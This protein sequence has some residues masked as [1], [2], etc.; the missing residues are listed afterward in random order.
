M[1]DR[2]G[3]TVDAEHRHRPRPAGDQPDRPPGTGRHPRAAGHGDRQPLGVVRRPS[4]SRRHRPGVPRAIGDRDDRAVGVR[5]VDAHPVPQPDARARS[6][7]AGAWRGAAPRQ[8]AVLGGRRPRRHPARGRHGVPAAQ[9]VP[10]E[11]DRRE[12][13]RPARA[14]I[15]SS[16]RAVARDELV[17]KAL[18]RRRAVERGQEPPRRARRRAVGRPAAA[19]VHRAGARGR[20]GR[21][22]DGRAVLRARSAVDLPDRG[23]D[24]RAQAPAH[25]RDR[26]PQHAAGRPRQ[27]L[28]G[29]HHDRERRRARAPC[30]V[31]ADA[32]DLH[33]PQHERTEAYVTG[34]FG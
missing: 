33:R 12:H 21:P 15:A 26:D 13:A 34:R 4:G 18:R 5:Q 31:R 17:E 10:D 28:H 6:G 30:R 14:S 24:R 2:A 25:D 11:V 3:S 1:N 20:A 19:P 22:A 27:R 16:S 23:P 29:V 7:R 8:G 32:P 9:P